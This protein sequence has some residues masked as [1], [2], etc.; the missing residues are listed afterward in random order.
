MNFFPPE[1]GGVIV[2]GAIVKGAI[3]EALQY[4]PDKLY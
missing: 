2:D 4:L 3:L 1:R